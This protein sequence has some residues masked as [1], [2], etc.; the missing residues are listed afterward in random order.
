M[1]WHI[2]VTQLSNR[3]LS[4]PLDLLW[5]FP[6]TKLVQTES[7]STEQENSKVQR[8]QTECF[9]EP[10]PPIRTKSCAKQFMNDDETT[11]HLLTI[12]V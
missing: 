4:T 6:S 5:C 8:E 7:D 10:I 11:P 12:F 3:L 1:K 9:T 2:L